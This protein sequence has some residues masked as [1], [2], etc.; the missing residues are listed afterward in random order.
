[1]ASVE[2][3]PWGGRKRVCIARENL[4]TSIVGHSR[5]ARS[6]SRRGVR[7]NRALGKNLNPTRAVTSARLG[8]FF[9]LTLYRGEQLRPPVGAH[10]PVFQNL[11]TGQTREAGGKEALATE[12]RE[13]TENET[14]GS[15]HL[16]VT[17]VCSVA[18]FSSAKSGNRPNA[19]GS[20]PEEKR[21]WPRRYART[22]RRK[23]MDLKETDFK[24]S[25]LCSPWL[26]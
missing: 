18:S 24:N 1:M 22:Q 25:S 9:A 19:R 6:F 11:K 4:F 20:R 15:H 13:D 3:Q 26:F 5:R 2:S 23:I 16:L 7:W 14:H 12:V 8:Q 21:H 10:W 17:S